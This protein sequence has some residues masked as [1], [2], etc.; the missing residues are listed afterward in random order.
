[1]ES[2]QKVRTEIER[3]ILDFARRLGENNTV[4]HTLTLT[5]T[6]ARRGVHKQ[7]AR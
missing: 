3:G 5:W 1:M 2:Y 4:F 7:S 6:L